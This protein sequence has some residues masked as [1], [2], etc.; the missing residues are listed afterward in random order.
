MARVVT[1]AVDIVRNLAPGASLSSRAL[2]SPS[3]RLPPDRSQSPQRSH[4]LGNKHLKDEPASISTTAGRT[5]L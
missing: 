1:A 2:P 4:Q 3:D 5:C